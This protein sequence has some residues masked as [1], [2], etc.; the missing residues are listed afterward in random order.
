MADRIELIGVRCY[1]YHGV[2][3][4]ERQLGQEFRVDLRCWLDFSEAA[5]RDDLTHTINY[6]ELADLAVRTVEGPPRQLIETVAAEIAD[7]A[8]DTYPALFAIEVTIHKPQAPIPH[9]F[10]DVAVVARRSRKG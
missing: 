1:G 8:M 3:E 4:Y 9:C 5:R 6:A 7:T 2:L 10:E